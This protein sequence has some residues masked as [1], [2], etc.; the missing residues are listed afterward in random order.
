MS[1]ITFRLEKLVIEALS[2]KF[3][4]SDGTIIPKEKLAPAIDNLIYKQIL[5]TNP[6]QIN[7]TLKKIYQI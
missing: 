5:E 4:N 6:E 1:K 7:I 3:V 2:I